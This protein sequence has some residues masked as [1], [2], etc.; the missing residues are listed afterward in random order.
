MRILLIYPIVGLPSYPHHGLMSISAVLKEHGCSVEMVKITSE[1][2]EPDLVR[3][4]TTFNPEV[5]FITAVT[6]QWD[7]VIKASEFIGSSYG[8]PIFI[9]GPHVT[10][11]PQSIHD[12]EHIGGIC[13][14]EGEN[15]ILHLIKRIEKHE[16]YLD[17]PNFWF[18]TG[19]GIVT[20]DVGPL[21]SDVDRLPL[22]D[23]G[24]FGQ[25]SHLKYPSFIFS[26]GCPFICAY[27]INYTYHKLYKDRET[28]RYKNITK[29]IMEISKLLDYQPRIDCLYFDDDNF[30]KNKGW[31]TSF[32]S[33]YS[34][35]FN[36]P[37]YCNSRPELLSYD[38]LR[39]LSDS[40][41]SGIGIGVESGD[42]E[43]R[44]NVLGRNI[45]DETIVRAFRLA[46][47]YGLE[48][49]SFN[50]IGIPG[51]NKDRFLKTVRLNE[52]ANPDY[53]QISIYYPFPGTELGDYCLK[54]Q[55]IS[56]RR[57]RSFYNDTILNLP[58]FSRTQIRE[59][60]KAWVE[61]LA[62]E[63]KLWNPEDIANKRKEKN[64]L[65]GID[66]GKR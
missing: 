27:C 2:F 54:N 46:K 28:V 11:N 21:I 12:S 66:I 4:I 58:S 18:N 14:G 47:V 24:L 32:L 59:C 48:T 20:N 63:G 57:V 62:F 17:T 9:G 34:H 45:S 61:Q 37:F 25:E 39:Q 29:A 56:N 5:V 8:I 22:P 35:H 65:S 19:D 26:R 41:C 6:T 15:S 31:L 3:K 42:S 23:L 52:K 7:V 40:G 10:S 16:Y 55:Y 44:R 30:T 53:V 36:I 38:V 50:M 60:F 49:W 33:A 51:E 1:S 43:I 64:Y 13:R